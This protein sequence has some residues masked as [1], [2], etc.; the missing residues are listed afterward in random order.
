MKHAPT[1]AEKRHM[2]RVAQLPCAICGQPGPSIVH[3]MRAGFGGAQRAPNAL[4]MPLC[5]EHHVG[6]TGIHGDRSAWRLRNIDEYTVLADTIL[7]L[8]AMK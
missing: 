5:W 4:T 8:E 6:K 2:A 7:K 3:H 1:A